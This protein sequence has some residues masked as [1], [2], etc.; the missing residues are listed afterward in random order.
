[1]RGFGLMSLQ[2]QRNLDITRFGTM[3]TPARAAFV[4]FASELHELREAIAFAHQHALPWFTLGGGS[5]LIL[6]EQFEGLVVR[7][8]LRGVGIVDQDAQTVLLDVAAGENWHDLVRRSLGMGLSGLE[9]MALI[10]GTVGA[11]PVQNIGAYGGELSDVVERVDVLLTES[12]VL[13][14]LAGDACG[15]SYR[16][17]SFKAAG[18]ARL[19][20]SVQLRLRRQSAPRAK[21]PEVQTELQRMGVAEPNAIQYAEAVIAVRRR[22]LPDPRQHGNVGS[23]FKNPVLDGN[24]AEALFERNP[25]L[26]GLARRQAT[27]EAFAGEHGASSAAT[28]YKLPAA[29]LIERAGWKGRVDGR[30]EAWRRQPLVLV[31]R[32]GASRVDVLATASRI[33][34]DVRSQFAVQLQAEPRLTFPGE[35]EVRL[36][37]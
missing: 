29:A 30:V 18:E 10:P 1:M 16:D 26:R 17:S 20:T 12:S 9:A 37:N 35:A 2:I 8:A 19:I 28:H 14:T 33:A 13:Q 32:G 7:V 25:D 36:S 24:Q 22:K 4:V 31:N 34:D 15:F 27:A 3:G 23:F 5:N 6:P 11:A 21:Y